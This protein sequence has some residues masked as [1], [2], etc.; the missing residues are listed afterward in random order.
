M[1]WNPERFARIFR[2]NV[3]RRSRTAQGQDKGSETSK[4]K[5][6][7]LL[8]G[9]ALKARV[10]ANTERMIDDVVASFEVTRAMEEDARDA[11]VDAVHLR[12]LSERWFDIANGGLYGPDSYG[13]EFRKLEE[14]AALLARSMGGEYRLNRRYRL[15][16]PE[17]TSLK[18]PPILLEKYMDDFYEVLDEHLWSAAQAPGPE[19]AARVMAY[20]DLMMDGELHPWMDAC[21]RVS[22][23]LV[24]WISAYLD[25][26]PPLFAP[27][28]QEHY[29][30][31]RDIDLHAKY[32][33]EA[34]RRA[35][36]EEP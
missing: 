12:A 1:T 5:K 2:L 15:W 24:M 23:A 21:G 31:I 16:T 6:P 4:S 17:Y 13:E 27:T 10:A 30:D 3:Q 19:A 33:M 32:F 7:L 29:A 36:R 14:D 25:V 8:S 11:V 28:K 26:S 35:D 20:A 18:V 34:M 9:E 22:T